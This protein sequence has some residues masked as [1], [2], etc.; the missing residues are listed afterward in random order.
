MAVQ[1]ELSIVQIEDAVASLSHD[2]RQRF[3]RIF[4]VSSTLGHLAPPDAMLPWIEKQF[5][6]VD[7][8]TEQKIVTVTNNVTLE[9]VLFN[10][11]RSSRPMWRQEIDL[12]SELESGPPDPL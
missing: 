9:A 10:W 11:L 3:E 6:S 4:S 8:T 12:D 2:E 5:G 1:Q 7:A